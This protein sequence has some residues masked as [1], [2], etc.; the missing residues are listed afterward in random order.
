MLACVYIQPSESKDIHPMVL[1][2]FLVFL[3]QVLIFNVDLNKYVTTNQ[4]T[5]VQ[6]SVICSNVCARPEDGY[7]LSRNMLPI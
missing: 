7:I 5:A 2:R 3:I 1:K 6:W 4:T